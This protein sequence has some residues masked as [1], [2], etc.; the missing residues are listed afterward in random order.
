LQAAL[1]QAQAALAR[2]KAQL[3]NAKRDADRLAPLM[4]RDFVS[5]Q[6]FDQARTTAAALEATVQADQAQVEAAQVQIS[7]TV[8]RTPIPGRLGTI[9]F[10]AGNSIKANDTMPLATLN[11]IRPIYVSFS[12]PQAN[13]AAIQQAMKK[14]PLK[15][16]ATVPGDSAGPLDGQL[17]YIENAIDATTN[18]LSLKAT[19]GNADN[20]LWPGQFVNVTVTLGVQADAVVVPTEAVQAGQNTSFAYVLKPDSTVEARPITVDRTIGG[21]AVIAK[22]IAA[23]EKVVVNGQLRLDDGTKVQVKPAD[24]TPEREGRVS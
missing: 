3:E 21:E 11:Q 2:D 1:H 22:G 24:E 6:Q 15:V 7:Y 9:N 4:Q 23:G 14:H 20:R 10:K 18:T 5:R 17:A 16:E 8:I 13:F 12:L 19:F